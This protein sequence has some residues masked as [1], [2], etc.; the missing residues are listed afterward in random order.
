LTEDAVEALF[1]DNA[2]PCIRT[3]SHNQA[4]IA[5]RFEVTMNPAPDFVVFDTTDTVRAMLEVSTQIPVPRRGCP[6]PRLFPKSQLRLPSPISM[7]T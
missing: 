5:A 6:T 2:V 3:G 7:C 4:E 1:V